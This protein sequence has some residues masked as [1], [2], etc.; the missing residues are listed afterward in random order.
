MN[1]STYPNYIEFGIQCA[2]NSWY[3]SFVTIPSEHLDP[4]CDDELNV[5]YAV[6]AT[7]Q[8]INILVGSFDE[9]K[10]IFWV[11]IISTVRN[12]KS[13]VMFAGLQLI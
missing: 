6:D 8:I 11:S 10:N 5:S 7:V 9:K 2:M 3:K 12:H 1:K 4:P 13:Y